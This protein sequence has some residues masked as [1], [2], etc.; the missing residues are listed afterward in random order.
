MSTSLTPLEQNALWELEDMMQDTSKPFTDDDISMLAGMGIDPKPIMEAYI[1]EDE[2]SG[3]GHFVSDL[4]RGLERGKHLSVA[5]TRAALNVMRE[6]VLGLKPSFKGASPAL[7]PTYN[8]A[9]KCRACDATFENLA[10]LV[11]HRIDA[12]DYKPG[13]GSLDM[14]LVAPVA[15]LGEEEESGFDASVIPDGYYAVPMKNSYGTG[16][17]T[18]LRVKRTRKNR[19]RNR[20]YTYGRIITGA[21]I[22]PAGTIEVAEMSGD[23]KKLVG[24]DRGEQTPGSTYK[25][26]LLD[27]L[28]LIELN[29]KKY[30]K[31][32]AEEIGRCGRCGKTLTDDISRSD[33]FGP[34]CIH[35][36]DRHFI[37]EKWAHKYEDART[38]TCPSVGCK[39]SDGHL[40]DG[41]TELYECSNGH[42]WVVRK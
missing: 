40:V 17:Y 37:E 32:F 35:L 15:V 8:Y 9:G 36:V 31:R 14:A 41:E 26:A 34:D 2:A 42:T 28:E 10:E 39:K 38:T 33:G 25:G 3:K 11:Q 18:F 1:R 19:L 4:R 5:Q 12:H 23:T 6:K 27:H 13:W 7:D 16:E 21:E 20:R 22:V 29:P 30:A 24:E